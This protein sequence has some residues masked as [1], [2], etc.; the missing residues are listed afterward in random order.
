[1]TTDRLSYRRTRSFSQS[2]R[3]C[4]HTGRQAR[5]QATYTDPLN[6]ES[7]SYISLYFQYNHR[8]GESLTV[9]ERGNLC[10]QRSSDNSRFLKNEEAVKANFTYQSGLRS[11]MSAKYP[12]AS[13]KYA[14]KVFT[15]LSGFRGVGKRNEVK[16]E[17]RNYL[18]RRVDEASSRGDAEGVG[19]G[20]RGPA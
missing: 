5:S 7:F 18:N 6:F 11:E 20:V 2:Y 15:G 3:N 10:R 4:K 1:M 13:E 19:N 9:I 8:H 17:T 14:R 12:I 16:A